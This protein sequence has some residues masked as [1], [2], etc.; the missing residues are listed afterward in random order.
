MFGMNAFDTTVEFLKTNT[1]I[2]SIDL[3][4]IH[5]VSIEDNSILLLCEMLKTNNTLES[6]HVYGFHVSD[7][8]FSQLIDALMINRRLMCFEISEFP[9]HTTILSQCLRNLVTINRE[10]PLRNFKL[11]FRDKGDV[12]FQ[13]N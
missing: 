10:I 4:F 5:W 11:R 3:S 6:L 8:C 1:T 7:W 9:T 12:K 2:V 13:F